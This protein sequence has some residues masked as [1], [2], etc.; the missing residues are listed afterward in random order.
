MSS[1]TSPAV[2]L[3]LAKPASTMAFEVSGRDEM[4]HRTEI[5]VA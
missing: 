1:I 3:L 2:D 4:E 5:L